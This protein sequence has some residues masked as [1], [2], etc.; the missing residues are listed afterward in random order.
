MTSKIPECSI[1]FEHYN[2]QS[3]AALTA[4]KTYAKLQLSFILAT[5]EVTI[6][7]LFPLRSSKQ[8]LSS[9]L[10][11][12]Y[13]KN[14]MINSGFL[15]RNVVMQFVGNALLLNTMRSLVFTTC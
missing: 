3:N 4:K 1:C 8:T 7:K 5:R 2:D 9:L 11:P 13:T 14:T 15:M 6:I 10:Y 12:S